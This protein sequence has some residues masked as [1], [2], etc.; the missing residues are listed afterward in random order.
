MYIRSWHMRKN[1]IRFIIMHGFLV[2]SLRMVLRRTASQILRI[3]LIVTGLILMHGVF[4]CIPN[5]SIAM[6]SQ[7]T[8]HGA[9]AA[10]HMLQM[11][12]D[13]YDK[14]RSN[15]ANA[16][17]KIKSLLIYNCSQGGNNRCLNSSIN[18]LIHPTVACHNDAKHKL[19]IMIFSS[20]KN[21]EN[22]KY[23]RKTWA[24]DFNTI[25]HIFLLGITRH[26]GILKEAGDY[27]DILMGEFH[28]TYKNLTLKTIMG[29]EWFH[30][31]CH[32][33]D[34]LMKT[35]DDMYINT[36]ALERFVRRSTDGQMKIFGHCMGYTPVDRNLSNKWSMTKEEY[37]DYMF[38]HYCSGTG[39]V[40]GGTAAHSVATELRW[41]PVI[42]IEDVFTGIAIAR[43]EEKVVFEN[44]IHRFG[45]LYQNND[46]SLCE[47]LIIGRVFTIHRVPI[48]T[49]VM[50]DQ[51]CKYSF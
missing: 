15:F 42:S 41:I 31:N 30:S 4:N 43:L 21:V 34:F 49:M 46:I 29:Y 40:I 7:A 44:N 26:Q 3:L 5:K 17:S 50:F 18:V 24:K 22:R 12:L 47:R 14:S 20:P 23:I 11:I 51:N 33:V 6:D 1:N 32:H 39:Y 19:V 9:E 2:S 25:T 38:P 37:P 8:I 10:Q 35:D 27:G 28:D 16:S 36:A 45:Q 48:R 13:G